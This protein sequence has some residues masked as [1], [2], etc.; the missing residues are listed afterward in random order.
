MRGSKAAPSPGGSWRPF[1]PHSGRSTPAGTPR[2]QNAPFGGNS[3]NQRPKSAFEYFKDNSK[4]QNPSSPHSPKKRNGFAPGTAGGD[5]PMARNTSSYT[6]TRSERPS[7]MFFDPAPPPTAKKPRA[8]SP[9][10][11]EFEQPKPTASSSAQRPFAPEYQRTGS[12]YAASGGEK[13]FFSSSGLGRSAT[14][15]TP[16]GSYR[17]S[18][19]RTNP[20]TPEYPPSPRH[21]SASPNSRQNNAYSSSTSS[22]NDDDSEDEFPQP[23]RGKPKAVPKSRLRPHQKFTD[24]HRDDD[25][26]ST[27]GEDPSTQSSSQRRRQTPLPDRASRR[28]QSPVFVDL[29]ADSDEEKGHNSDSATGPFF[30]PPQT[31][32]SSDSHSARR[33]EHLS[34]TSRRTPYSSL[35]RETPTGNATGPQPTTSG[36]RSSRD[37]N[38]LH[39]KFSAEDW[40]EPSSFDFLGANATL[41]GQHQKSP[42]SQTGGKTAPQNGWAQPAK[43]TE[44]SNQNQNTFPQA[45]QE[46]TGFAQARFSADQW[47]EQLRDLAWNVPNVEKA[48]QTGN[49]PPTRS[50]RKQTR[51]GTKV[52]SGPQSAS[53]ATEAEEARE[54]VN[55]DGHPEP[56][57]TVPDDVEAMDIDDE[58]PPLNRSTGGAKNSSYPDLNSHIPKAAAPGP[59]QPGSQ[60]E[61]NGT[62]NANASTPLFD[63][64]PLRKTAPFTNT[65]SSGI[66]NLGDVHATLPF[67]SRAKE[68][69]TTQRDIRPRELKLP[70]PPKRPTA[71]SPAPLQPGSQQLVLPREKWNWYVSAM[72]TYMHEW[73]NFNRR[74]LLHFNTRQEAIETGLAPG[75]ISAVGDSARL[76]MNGTDEDDDDGQGTHAGLDVNPN[77]E[78]LVPGT[79]K[80][81]FSAYLRGIEEDMQVRKHW[82][83]ACEMHRECILSLGRLREW[84]RSGGKVI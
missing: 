77:D 11:T 71:P 57:R 68:P 43:S 56:A 29:T 60:T 65:N 21:R 41:K 45:A 48:R 80:G 55:G 47:A 12:R 39:R 36:R 32:Y 27:A 84:I 33:Y 62:S 16:S 59:G 20:P 70:N 34:W 40:R 52:R 67:E 30:R 53:V 18:N 22:S 49:T 61:N 63:L 46:P 37:L 81:G 4:T 76:K 69:V 72:G 44:S 24:F 2:Q 50:P 7:S 83:V 28:W 13:T 66:D 73:N 64:D 25:S 79:A 54:T 58:L 38:G 78:S 14:T 19:T 17:T 1:D 23:T 6:S 8:P 3:G 9:P 42:K 10:A 51:S 31:H 35:D 5:E 74:M 82:E 15:R 75:W 26:S